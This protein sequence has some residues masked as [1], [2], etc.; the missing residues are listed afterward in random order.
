VEED[1]DKLSRRELARV[2]RQYR[3]VLRE[4]AAGK[5]GAARTSLAELEGEAIDGRSLGAVG[6][7]KGAELSVLRDVAQGSP[8]ILLPPARLH[9]QLLEAYTR[10]RRLLL[11]VHAREMFRALLAEY[12][13][14]ARA[15]EE[16]RMAASLYARFGVYL[17]DVALRNES[18][19]TFRTA[20]ELDPANE[21]ALR[22]LAA[23]YERS[24]EMRPAAELLRNL[25]DLRGDD[26]EACVRLGR[27][28]SEGGRP[29]QGEREW[30]TCLELQRPSWA[31]E[32]AYQELARIQIRDE[33]W[34]AA[35]EVLR[36]AG[37][38][39]PREERLALLLSYVL[40]RQQKTREG[41]EVL[42]RHG[43]SVTSEASARYRYGR[44]PRAAFATVLRETDAAIDEQLPGLAEAVADPKKRRSK[45]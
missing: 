28:L 32:L 3:E 39:F 20:L 45:R 40:D 13:S 16:Q 15:P 31:V 14:A 35:E 2:S 17:Q 6:A 5:S 43:G 44:W 4:L 34:A 25:R 11:S 26:A 42:V 12:V 18:E 37:E 30:R 27:A 7:L 36:S 10:D 1:K 41:R 22:A 8:G 24:S 23:S 29:T 19:Q 21:L 38:R 9:F 33:G